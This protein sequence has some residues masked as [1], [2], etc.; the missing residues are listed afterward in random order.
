MP[1]NKEGASIPDDCRD[2]VHWEQ[3]EDRIRIHSLLSSMV[4]KLEEKLNSA[5]FKPGVGDLLKLLEARKSLEAPDQG[6]KELE[7][8]WADPANSLRS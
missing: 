6:P 3:M 7:V 8:R 4:A 1:K 5:D 2:C